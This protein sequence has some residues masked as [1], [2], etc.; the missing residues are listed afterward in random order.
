MGDENS[1]GCGKQFTYRVMVVSFVLVILAMVLVITSV[2]IPVKTNN[3]AEVVDLTGQYE[4]LMDSQT[5]VEPLLLKMAGRRLIRPSQVKAAVKDTGAAAQLLKKLT[6]Q[7]VVQIGS[8][9]VAYIRVEKKGTRNVKCGEKVLEFVVQKIE[10]GKITL[11]LEGVEVM[12][13]H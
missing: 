2:S 6:L 1:I 5:Y 4:P 12:L 3:G 8:D 10:P 7:G 13:K 9:Q 11:S